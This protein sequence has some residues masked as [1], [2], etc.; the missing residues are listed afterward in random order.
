ML[1]LAGLGRSG[2]T[3]IERTLAG[4]PGTTSVGELVFVWE[5][6]VRRNELCGCGE[7]FL[8]CPFWTEVGQNAFGGWDTVSVEHVLALQRSVD[9]NRFIPGLASAHAT[10]AFSGRLDEFRQILSMLYA[11]IRDVAGCDAIIDSSKHVSYAYVLRGTPGIDLRVLHVVRDSPAVAHSWNKVVSRPEGRLGGDPLMT[12]WTPAK[13]AGHW[14]VQNLL[15]ES[16]AAR[17]VPVQRVRY[18][19]FVAEPDRVVRGLTGFA[20]GTP[21]AKVP[22]IAEGLVTLGTHHSVSGNPMR[23]TTGATQLAADDAWRLGLS[24]RDRRMVELIT[25]P[26]R[27]RYGYPA[28]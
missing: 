24:A 22:G 19:D 2:T 13:T 25:A 16:L 4:L 7:R 17:S 5:R 27:Y 8:S 11:A 6:G 26:L 18:E 10:S 3:I 21:G 14:V 23:F 28:R 9:R 15:A 1:Y 20:V 12:R